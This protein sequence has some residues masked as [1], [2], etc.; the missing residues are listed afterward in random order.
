[1]KGKIT[2]GILIGSMLIMTTAC[3]AQEQ[4]EA[5]VVLVQDNSQETYHTATVGYGDVTKH[6]NLNC[7]YTATQTQ[8]LSF[9]VDGY[10]IEKVN[11]KKG[12]YVTKG[13]LLVSLDVQDLKEQIEE[14]EYKIE[15]LELKQKQTYELQDFDLESADTLFE[16]TGKSVQ[17]RNELKKK[18]ENILKQY[19]T[20]LEDLEDSILVEKDRLATEKARYEEGQMFAGINGELTYIKSSLLDTYSKKDELV[21][22]ISDQDTCYFVSDAMEYADFF[23][24]GETLELTYRESGKDMVCPVQPALKESWNEEMYFK[25]VDGELIDTGKSGSLTLELDSRKNV[26]CVPA[27]AVHES[28][29]GTFVYLMQD[30][31]PQMRYV[32]LGLVGDDTA[33]ITD[34]LQPGEIIALTK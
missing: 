14:Q 32:T 13:Q 10:L 4:K 28:S 8:N 30:G 1:M 9:P 18:K 24:E 12:D 17:D 25:P 26:L 27:D 3:G 5:E 21:L 33:E 23:A 31:L 6:V 20:T 34:G 22:T 15:S 2:A 16:Y 19:K 29:N 11:V 7:T